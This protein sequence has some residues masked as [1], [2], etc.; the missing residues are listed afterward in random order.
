MPA[1]CPSWPDRIA[2]AVHAEFARGDSLEYLRH[3]LCIWSGHRSARSQQLVGSRVAL[4]AYTGSG[5]ADVQLIDANELATQLVADILAL[6]APR[7]E[8][9]P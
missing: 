1:E 8:H 2:G 5:V 7:V 4:R 9:T 6:K 3:S